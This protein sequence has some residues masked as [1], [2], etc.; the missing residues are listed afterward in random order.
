MEGQDGTSRAD[1]AGEWRDVRGAEVVCVDGR[2]VCV[3]SGSGGTGSGCA[4]PDAK[5]EVCLVHIKSQ[6]LKQR[7]N[8][9]R[10]RKKR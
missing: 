7:E 2:R 3:W 6:N 8:K 5:E 1:M 4:S 10:D 9:E